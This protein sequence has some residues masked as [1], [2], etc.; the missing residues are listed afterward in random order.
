MRRGNRTDAQAALSD[1]AQQMERCRSSAGTFTGC[2]ALGTYDSPEGFYE[3]EVVT[4]GGGVGFTATAKAKKAP[5]TGDSGCTSLTLDHVGKRTP[6]S[7][8]CW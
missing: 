2:S 8:D 6:T 1:A 4:S 5:Q 3:V 7:G